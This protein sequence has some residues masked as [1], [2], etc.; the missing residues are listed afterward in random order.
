MQ[1]RQAKARN[2]NHY[3][4]ENHEQC[5]IGNEECAVEAPRKFDATIN[6]SGE[7]GDDSHKEPDEERFEEARVDEVD[8]AD[9]PG[10]F[11]LVDADR[12]IGAAGSEKDKGEDLETE[13]CQHDIL[14]QVGTLLIVGC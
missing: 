6:T 1:K 14:A 12:K 13:T 9:V 10:S 4:F 2:D 8:I 7:D 11:V 3:A 5:F